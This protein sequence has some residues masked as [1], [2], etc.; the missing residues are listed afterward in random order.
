MGGKSSAPKAPDY[1]ALAEKQG[2]IN[3]STSLFDTKMN[4]PD[5]T[6]PFGSRN[7]QYDPRQKKWTTTTTLDPSTQAAVDALQQSGGAAAQG[8]PGLGQQIA[9]NYASPFSTSGMQAFGNVQGPISLPSYQ[10]TDPSAL[11]TNI[12]GVNN[13]QK[14]V[15]DAIFRNETRYYDDAFGRQEESLRTRLANQGL[16]QGSEAQGNAMTDF[17]RERNDA[18]ANAADRATIAGQKAGIE[19][20]GA[21][22]QSLGTQQNIRSAD[23]S[24]LLQGLMNQFQTGESSFNE[25]NALRGQQ[26]QEALSLRDLPMSELQALQG[27]NLMLP[28]FQG[29]YTGVGTTPQDIMSAGQSQYQGKLNSYNAQ[30]ANTAAQVQGGAALTSSIADLVK[31][32]R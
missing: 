27:M 5:E 4:R 2:E 31:A 11:P 1:I 3:K 13:I 8:A 9:S 25:A 29:Y 18:Y 22:G 17:L 19:D 21:L 14:D 15:A 32:F 16:G 30:N 10:K 28:S 23:Y 26:L 12:Q 20:I 6:N 24:S 7:W